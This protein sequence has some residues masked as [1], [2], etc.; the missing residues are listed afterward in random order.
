MLYY[1]KMK[2]LTIL[3]R[4]QAPDLQKHKS[5]HSLISEFSCDPDVQ[6]VSVNSTLNKRYIKDDDD[7]LVDHGE[8][9]ET[10]D[11]KER[12]TEDGEEREIEDGEERETDGGKESKLNEEKVST[13]NDVD[14]IEML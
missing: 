12:E 11:G 9:R 3:H 6:K 4:N 1:I 14:T 13:S 5:I 2:I 8:E 10:D 7:Y